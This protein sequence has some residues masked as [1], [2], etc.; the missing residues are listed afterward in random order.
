MRRNFEIRGAK[1]FNNLFSYALKVGKMSDFLSPDSLE[2]LKNIGK[3]LNFKNLVPK[4]RKT[5]TVIKTA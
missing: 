3:P 4:I 2:L 5:A 1:Q